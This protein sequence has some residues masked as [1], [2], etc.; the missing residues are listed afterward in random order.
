MLFRTLFSAPLIRDCDN[1]DK[2]F[3]PDLSIGVVR[4]FVNDR[5][6]FRSRVIILHT[7]LKLTRFGFA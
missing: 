7:K 4:L 1:N 6:G 2:M 5:Y 3:V